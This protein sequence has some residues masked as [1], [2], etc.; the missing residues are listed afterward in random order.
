MDSVTVTGGSFQVRDS[1]TLPVGAHAPSKSARGRPDTRPGSVAPVPVQN[2]T[3]VR[4][5]RLDFGTMPDDIH[6]QML[7]RWG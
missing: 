5:L 6:Y 1:V 2:S 3:G 7:G 4:S